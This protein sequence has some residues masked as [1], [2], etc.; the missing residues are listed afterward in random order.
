MNLKKDTAMSQRTAEL[1][2]DTSSHVDTGI[3]QSSPSLSKA[4]KPKGIAISVPLERV[5][6][7][8]LNL[9]ISYVAFLLVMTEGFVKI[10][11]KLSWKHAKF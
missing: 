6:L 8:T 11:Q 9:Q 7:L 1:I 10:Q 3:G 2:P 4:K 5:N